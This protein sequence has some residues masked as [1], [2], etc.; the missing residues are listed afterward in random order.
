MKNRE[1]KLTNIAV[2]NKTTVYIFLILLIIFGIMQYNATPKEEFPEIV[3]PYFVIA[4]LHPGTS[5]LE[6]ENLVTRPIEK[7]LKG[8]DGVKEIGSKSIQDFSSIFIEFEIDADETQAYLDVKQAVDD[9][10]TELPSDLFQEPEIRQIEF[11]ERPILYINL[12]GDLG[13]I[14]LKLLAEDLQEEIEG[15]EEI[16]RAD[17]VGALDRE[18][19]VNVD[20]YKM[21]AAGFTF[22]TLQNAIAAE[23]LT[24]SG[25][26][27]DKDSTKRNLR[28]VG[29]FEKVEEIANILLAE[30]VYVK[31]IAEVRDSH[32]DRESYSRLNSQDV[33]TLNVIKR[34]GKNLIYA[35]DKINVILEEF[36]RTA[37]QN[38]IVSLSGDSSEKTK[39]GVSDLMNTII[40]GFI[41][42]VFVLMFFMGET[43]ALFVG[44]A[45]PLSMVIAFIFVPLVGFTLNRVVLMSFLLVLGIVVDNAIVVVE[46]IYRH[47]TTT[48]NLPIL[49]ATKKAVGEVALPVF[50]GT[51]TTIAPFFPLIFTPGLAGKFMSYLPITIIIA[52]TASMFVAYVM[53]PVFAISFM[54]YRNLAEESPKPK[55]LG[56][57]NIV[58]TFGAVGAAVLF[59]A[60]GAM[61]LGNLLAFCVIIYY[62]AKY[63]LRFLVQQFQ[64]CA[65]P[66]M[67]DLYRKTLAFFLKGRRPYAVIF[68]IVLLLI[69]SI[70][71]LRVKTPR[72]VFMPRGE[73]NS[74]DIFISMPEGT[75]I[76]VTNQVARRVEEKVYELIG[77][78]NPDVE[79][80]VTN[81][82]ANAGS[83]RFQRFTEDKL[84]KVTINFV[85]YKLREGSKSTQDIMNDLRTELKGIPGA[86]IRIDR[87]TMGPPAGMPINIEISGDDI[88]ELIAISESLETFI[89]SQKIKGIEELKS[90]IEASK[91]EII[92]SVN[93]IKA[94]QL[95]ISTAQ[96]GMALRTAIYGSE[97]SKFREGEDE[98]P[99]QVRLAKRFRTDID[100]LLSQTIEVRP[101]SGGPPAR[102]P[103][104]AI[105]EVSYSS[106]YGSI[107]RIDNQRVITLSSNVIAGYNANEII[108][109]I[110]RA[111]PKF[112]I[113]Q[114]YDIG[115]TGEQDTQQEVGSYFVKALFIAIGLIFIILVAQFNSLSKPLIIIVQIFF[116]LTGVLLGFS[117]FG[118]D[119]S[120][121]MTGMGIIAVA[122]IVVKNGIIIIDYTDKLIA[123]GMEKMEA[124]IQAGA[125]RLTPVLLTALSTIL[126]LLPLAIGVNFNF[127]TL[128]TDFDPQF[129][130]GGD[131]AAFWNPLAWTI[132][133]GL[134]FATILTLIVIPAMYALIFAR[135][136]RKS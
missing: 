10:R 72:I 47:F 53:N 67:M 2:E 122:G 136:K 118:I 107:T 12:S 65:L 25:G 50:T 43:N 63:V 69:M 46:N 76:N 26:Q 55:K 3:F 111:L 115:F 96:I 49:P 56:K 116:S 74:L 75:H 104:S 29:E 1:F 52:L 119:I 57:K 28:I 23:N 130:I 40:L 132:I 24:I 41:V 21:Q 70:M 48:E 22:G 17:I 8:I 54:K 133:F 135:K 13:L 99:I 11:S 83:E 128:F 101:N 88:E 68:S 123:S 60:T 121:L 39:N 37:P 78:D 102:I 81:V 127:Q 30:G 5:P 120:V 20:L 16:L 90:S 87:E 14:K 129:Y 103:L 80:V 100:V 71:M 91:P 27:I 110:K 6:M 98:Y 58:I 82:A 84:A 124:I 31:D 126:G 18:I 79:S 109:Q 92:L 38:L 66:V 44:V 42:V 64:C 34:G 61:F 7:H 62:L 94:N 36:K 45:I 15:L 33:V 106:S 108:R 19:Q 131:N 4:T 117:L 105:A 59:Y 93:R 73:P 89:K 85:E 112:E 114:G 77:R 51:L 35:V 113:K 125:T 97:V 9:A 86:E 134:A 95:G 32:A